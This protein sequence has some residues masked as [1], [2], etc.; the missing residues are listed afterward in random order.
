[1]QSTKYS[2]LSILLSAAMLAGAA[3]GCS[4]T[5][6]RQQDELPPTNGTVAQK[7]SGEERSQPVKYEADDL[8]FDKELTLPAGAVTAVYHASL[9]Q[10]KEQGDKAP[11]LKKINEYYET[12]LKALQQDCESYFSQIQASY[13]NTWQIA[14]Q[15]AAVYTVDFTYEI[16]TAEADRISVIRT[17]KYM[18]I[19]MKEKVV[20]TGETFDC[21]TGWPMKLAEL[22]IS[23]TE[24]VEKV[25]NEQLDAWCAGNGV[26]RSLLPDISLKKQDCSFAVSEDTLY[27]CLDENGM[28][29]ISPGAR[30]IEIPL[31]ELAGVIKQ[32]SGK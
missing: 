16:V 27:L 29:S 25:L 20:Y 6:F 19:N 21:T 18:D 5:R 23:D 8:I 9:P 13:G 7:E 31:A 3:G 24:K 28:S 22:F 30:L 4:I 14:A 11:I 26:D 10:F 12:E 32:E 17:Y 15:A 2:A 1:M